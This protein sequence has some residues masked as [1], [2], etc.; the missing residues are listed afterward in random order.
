MYV[1]FVILIGNFIRSSLV[2]Q[3]STIIMFT[4]LPDVSMIWQLLLDIYLVREMKEY[5]LEEE[6][7]A[8]LIF[9][10]RSP[11]IMIKSTRIRHLVKIKLD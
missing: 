2:S 3:I 10:Y 8:K 7:F 9:L 5:R 4:E 6:L 1:T 11:N